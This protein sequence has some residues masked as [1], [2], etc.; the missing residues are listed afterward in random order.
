MGIAD[1]NEF[2]V[3]IKRTERKDTEGKRVIDYTVDDVRESPSLELIVQ[4]KA[5]G[6]DV[7]YNDPHVA[8]THR[9]RNYDLEMQSVPID[10]AKLADY[11]CVVVATHHKAYDWQQIADHAKLVVDARGALREV[12]GPIDH[13][14]SA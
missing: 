9:M 3:K 13:I 2:W 12:Q 8:A 14:Y 6:A 11:D 4:L 10:D 1:K 5:L 7:S